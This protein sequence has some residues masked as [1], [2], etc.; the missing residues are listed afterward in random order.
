LTQA[1]LTS[2]LAV[3]GANGGFFWELYKSN[4]AA[5]NVDV[6]S[7]AQQICKAALGASTK[8]CAGVIPQI[9]G[10]T[11]TTT[12]V[13]TGPSTSV[14][15]AVPTTTATPGG[16][17]VPAWSA[18]A[19]YNAND[20]VSYN[21]H[22]Y[23]AQW[24][25]QNNVPTSGAPWVDNGVCGTSPTSTTGP[26]PTATPSGCSAPAW[27]PST[28]YTT[29]SKVSYGGYI[30]TAQWWTQND[31]PGSSSAWTKSGSCTALRRR[32]YEKL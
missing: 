29:G 22:Q 6:T 13:P 23:T 27:S 4:G 7:A 9:D 32:L 25:S 11:P 24:W 17:S 10:S 12:A 19:V 5:G 8:R 21:G 14:S 15:T 20:K 3:Q 1:E 31:T 2:I 16:C 28:A 30:Y 18:S 26:T